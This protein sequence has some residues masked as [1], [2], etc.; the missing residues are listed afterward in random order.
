MK[1]R[2]VLISFMT[3]AFLAAPMAMAQGQ[4]QAQPMPQQQEAPDVSDEQINAFVDAYVAVSEVREEYTAR[5]Q[6]ADSQ[7]EAQELQ[8]EANDAMTAAI[9]DSGLSI[10]EYQQVAMAVNADAEVREQVT[11]MLEERGA[12]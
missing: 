2:N 11:T 12:L 10:E 4:Q 7:E 9:E 6:E 1:I 8:Q 5:L 3:A